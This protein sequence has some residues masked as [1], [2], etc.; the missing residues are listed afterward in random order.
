MLK[1][2]WK[3]L[4]SNKLLF[5][6]LV[7]V[8]LVPTLYTVIFLR[9]M[10][11]PYGNLDQLP[12]ALVNLDQKTS[13]EDRTIT[14]GDDLVDRLM[15]DGSLDFHLI[16]QEEAQQGMQDGD[17]YMMITIPEDFSEKALTVLDEKPEKM[18]LVYETNPGAN[19][20]SS[21]MS[22]SAMKTISSE[23]ADEVTKEYAATIF[24]IVGDLGDGLSEAADGA[25][26]ISDGTGD[27]QE[28]NEKITDNLN[29][30]ADSTLTFKDG[31]NE[32]SLGIGQYMD[33][34]VS[35]KN[36]AKKLD[37][38]TKKLSKGS[39][40][41]AKG[42]K[43]L[44]TG[45]GSLKQGIRSYTKGVASAHSG[46]EKLAENNDALNAGAASLS[47]GAATLKTG[48]S[49]VLTGLNTM[50]ASLSASRSEE[51]KNKITTVTNGL[52]SLNSGIQQLNTAV[53]GINLDTGEITSDLTG[54]GTHLKEGG[55]SL[56]NAATSFQE[57]GENVKAVGTNVQTLSTYLP[58]ILASDSLT[59][60]EK[61]EITQT[62]NQMQQNLTGYEQNANA[63]AGALTSVQT[64]LQGAGT[65]ATK[66]AT[67]LGSMSGSSEGETDT[68]TSLKTNMNTIATNSSQLLPGAKTV[69]NTLDSGLESVQQALDK[70]GEKSEDMGLIQ[71]MSALDGGIATLQNGIDGENGLSKGISSYTSGVSTL[72]QGLA[73]LDSNSA[74]LVNGS[75]QLKSGTKQLKDSVP[76]LKSGIQQLKTGSHKLYNGSL[77]LVSNNTALTKGIAALESGA[78]QLNDGAGQLADGS[79]TLGEGMVTLAD[80]AEELQTSL[81]DGADEI[82]N[83]V[84]TE[85]TSDM[86]SSPVEA[87]ETFYTTIDNNGSAMAAYM[88][89][90]GLWVAGIAFCVVFPM[91]DK[92]QKVKSGV[93]WWFS[94]LSVV[95]TVAIVQSLVMVGML[96][97]I[98]GLQPDRLP[99][100]L[101]V[102]ALTSLAYETIVYFLVLCFDKVGDFLALVILVI[103]LACCA[104]TYPI[105][106]S[107]HFFSVMNPLMPFTY[108]VHAFRATISASNMDI[109]GDIQ[110]LFGLFAVFA[111][112]TFAF[113]EYKTY[114]IRH[115]KKSR[116]HGLH[117]I[118]MGMLK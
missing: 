34:V 10:W 101:L 24:D 110:V 65:D 11:D 28:G 48:S 20:I 2:E 96:M 95:W 47:V 104:G 83:Q 115:H 109:T 7:A 91:K 98:N 74:A 103:Q 61:Q 69:I 72:N 56:G 43:K 32:L 71:G 100:L 38:G 33:G 42:V 50:S 90:V 17:Y 89:C 102:A 85:E 68:I 29:V 22:E 40:S 30:L 70:K 25:G 13:Y 36:G 80:G 21:K 87:E 49:A 51:N 111:V 45:A 14:A 106:T 92:R 44:D 97:A 53:Q 52:D 88:M 19:Y 18:E 59:A 63:V 35:L 60:E 107:E 15:E 93:T 54:V 108:S 27:L 6:F 81:Q 3:K 73:T 94:K 16:S 1:Q 57:A 77:Q 31:V 86:I 79:E 99:Q 5:V 113:F 84:M 26:K 78:V 67:A 12:V 66:V 23:V 39:N 46:S 112:L 76:S 75:K 8:A 117:A 4:F 114:L 118:C 37:A 58:Q 9:S 116:L 105:E 64:S 55:T 41:L 82:Q 62:F